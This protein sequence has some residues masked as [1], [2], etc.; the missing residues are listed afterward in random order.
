MMPPDGKNYF[1]PKGG[2]R[3]HGWYICDVSN[4]PTNPVHRVL[5]YTGFLSESGDPAGYSGFIALNSASR[6]DYRFLRYLKPVYFIGTTDELGKMK[7]QIPV[8]IWS[9][10]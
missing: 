2:W 3:E 8:E 1:R 9:K 6:D 5:F 4:G 7:T 10:K